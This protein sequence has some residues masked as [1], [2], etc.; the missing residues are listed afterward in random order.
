MIK[1]IRSIFE[2]EMDVDM[3]IEKSTNIIK[4]ELIL[5]NN[6]KLLN[7]KKV[8]N[9]SISNFYNG[10]KKLLDVSRFNSHL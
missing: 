6:L 9:Q 3:R 4:N 1:L 8:I 5:N 2:N 7:L 10:Q